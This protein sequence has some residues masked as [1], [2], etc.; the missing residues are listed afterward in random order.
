MDR[1]VG[2]DWDGLTGKLVHFT[3]HSTCWKRLE[4]I[5]GNK[6]VRGCEMC[7]NVRSGVAVGVFD[8]RKALWWL[9]YRGAA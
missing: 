5:N 3:L 9:R 2:V 6:L 4:T 8:F 1:S 7:R